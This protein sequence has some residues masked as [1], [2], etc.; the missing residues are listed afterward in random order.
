ML[1]MT[2]SAPDFGPCMTWGGVP[3]VLNVLVTRKT[4]VSRPIP[5]LMDKEL[6][7][8]YNSRS[9]FHSMREKRR[10]FNTG[11]GVFYITK[12]T[13]YFVPCMT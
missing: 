2:K 3:G 9:G 6:V 11:G 8:N 7:Q 1:Y 5:S 4:F 12:T 10:V 13:P